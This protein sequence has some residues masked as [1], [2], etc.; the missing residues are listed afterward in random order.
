MG[1]NLFFCGI[2]H[3]TDLVYSRRNWRITGWLL[4]FDACRYYRTDSANRHNYPFVAASI[5][6]RQMARLIAT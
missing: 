4:C 2:S 5:L 1:G 6:A 3:L